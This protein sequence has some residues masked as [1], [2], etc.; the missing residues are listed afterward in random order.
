M[1]LS[2]ITHSKALEALPPDSKILLALDCWTSQDQKPFL[3]IISYFI[4][5]KYKFH[6]VLLG[7]QH[8]KGSHEGAH[9][10]DIVMDILNKHNLCSYILAITTDN[11]SNNQIL[12]GAVVGRLNNSFNPNH[13]LINQPHHLPCLA[14]VIQITVHAFLQHLNIESRMKKFQQDWMMLKKNQSMVKA[15]LV[16]WKRYILMAFY[17]LSVVI[18]KLTSVILQSQI[19]KI[20]KYIND[21]PQ[22]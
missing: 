21:S 18:Y 17:L 11:T 19:Q 3:V 6:K 8:I 1:N 7:F 5:K 22:C 12:M 16:H 13:P 10:A 15:S 4:S 2:K 9:L 14:H 20:I